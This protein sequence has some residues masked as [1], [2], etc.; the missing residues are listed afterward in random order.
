VKKHLTENRINQS[1]QILSLACMRV[2]S[3]P[4]Q[5]ISTKV[6][7]ERDK[8]VRLNSAQVIWPLTRDLRPNGS[9]IADYIPERK[10]PDRNATR[11]PRRLV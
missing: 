1:F 5:K 8:L 9:R 2:A 6:P 10:N 3:S 11:P 4:D 7:R